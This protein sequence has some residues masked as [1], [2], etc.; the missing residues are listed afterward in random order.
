MIID[1]HVHI[2]RTEKINR[3]F[4]FKSF[5]HLMNK[6]DVSNAVVMPNLSSIMPSSGLNEIFMNDYYQLIEDEKKR[7]VPF[8]IIDPNDERTYH[9]LDFYYDDA[10]GAKFHPSISTVQINKP[11]IQKF[12]YKLQNKRLPLIVHC[13]RHFK[14]HISHLIEVANQFKDLTFIAAHMGGNASDLIEEAIQLIS[15]SK[16]Q[17]IYLDTSAVKL[18]WLIDEGVKELGVD[19]ILF[20]SDEPYSDLRI[21][22]YCIELTSLNSYDRKKLF[23]INAENLL[24]RKGK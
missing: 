20:G 8:L 5:L 24:T 3:S 12:L 11:E 9:Q 4:T 7:F 18:P 2:G 1:F 16:C 17:N 22:K 6:T 21:G 19:K 10:C 13:G 15:K 14:S 23:S